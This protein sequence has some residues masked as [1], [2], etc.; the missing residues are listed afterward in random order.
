MTPDVLAAIY[1]VSQSFATFD[2]VL[3]I[4][5]V[6]ETPPLQKL[7]DFV[8]AWLHENRDR[9]T[10]R[11]LQSALLLSLTLPN[12]ILMPDNDERAQLSAM[13]ISLAHSL[14]LQH[15]P[16][17]WNVPEE[18]K[19]LRRRLSCL[20][21]A[22][23]VWI[24]MAIG[25]PPLLSPDNWLVETVSSEDVCTSTVK[26]DTLVHFIHFTQLSQILGLMLRDV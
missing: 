23:D 25:R 10:L 3:C 7:N 26:G 21:K 17:N 13:I 15:D 19:A 12:D 18:E 20:V 1:L 16:S 14:G 22:N 11:S 5:T 8:W 6:Y 4:Q 2:E 24:A 9:P